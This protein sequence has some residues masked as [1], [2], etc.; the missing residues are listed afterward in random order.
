VKSVKNEITGEVVFDVE[1]EEYTLVL[2]I[3]A[4]SQ[5]ETVLTPGV[6][7]NGTLA[8]ISTLYGA[9]KRHHPKTR[10]ID[11]ADLVKKLTM[12]VVRELIADAYSVGSIP[13]TLGL[14]PLKAPALNKPK[15]TGAS[16]AR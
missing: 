15:K 11:A 3:Y 9:M 7:N 8:T 6:D 16:K 13:E 12:P 14:D 1:G 4:L 10:F 5:I 2:D